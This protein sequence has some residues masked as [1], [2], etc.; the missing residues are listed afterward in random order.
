MLN[1]GSPP[2]SLPRLLGI[3]F[4]AIAMFGLKFS[5]PVIGADGADLFLT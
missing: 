4:T 5:G 3:E 1:T 2:K